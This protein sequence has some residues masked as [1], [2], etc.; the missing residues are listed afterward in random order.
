MDEDGE[1]DVW[2]AG[3]QVADE[4]GEG[5]EVVVVAGEEGG[6]GDAG[7]LEEVGDF[8]EGGDGDDVG[9]DATAGEAGGEVGKEEGA[10]AAVQISNKEGHF[11]HSGMI[12]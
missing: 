3:F 5:G 12:R 1:D 2:L 9:I 7:G 6:S 10:A 11:G 8:T 4:F